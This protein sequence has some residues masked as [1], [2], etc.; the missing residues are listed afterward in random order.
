M[1]KADVSKDRRIEDVVSLIDSLDGYGVILEDADLLRMPWRALRL[2]L[3][4][5]HYCWRVRSK[6][7]EEVRMAKLWPCILCGE[8]VC[9]DPEWPCES[10]AAAELEPEEPLYDQYDDW[11]E[12]QRIVHGL[13]TIGRILSGDDD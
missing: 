9:P 13:Q 5:L 1:S 4:N 11:L 2:R 8:Y 12:M 10:C 7:F 6:L 3:A